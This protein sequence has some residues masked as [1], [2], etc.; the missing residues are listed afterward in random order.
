MPSAY[1][2]V[3]LVHIVS[4][5][6]LFG[7][8]LGTAFFMFNTYRSGDA[9]ALRVT[10]RH[11]VLADWLFTM[12]AVIVQL[13]TGL[14]L[15]RF[16]GI[17]WGSTWFITVITLFVVIGLCWLPVVLIQIRIS[18]LAAAAASPLDESVSAQQS[19]NAHMFRARTGYSV[20]I[21]ALMRVWIAFGVPAFLL[22]LV[23]FA[24]MVL[25]LGM[26]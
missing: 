23:L 9:G 5:T 25:K 24:M 14:W 26:G 1:L 8:G 19:A 2:L 11:V 18:R 10:S 13:G 20:E 22:T 3:K 12:P 7:T 17:S 6:L 4:A 16:L 21:N 15:S